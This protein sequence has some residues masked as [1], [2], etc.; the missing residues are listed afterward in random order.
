MITPVNVPK[1]GMAEGDITV[2]EWLRGDGEQVEAGAAIL[3]I[4]TAKASSEVEAPANGILFCLRQP[5]DMVKT[6]DLLGAIADSA[7][8]FET[9]KASLE[10]EGEAGGESEPAKQANTADTSGTNVAKTETAD[11]PSLTA[12]PDDGEARR[13]PLTGMRLAIARNMVASLQDA[14]QMTVVAETDL[15]ELGEFRK[16]LMLDS[17]EEKITYVDIFCKLAA[18]VLKEFPAVNSSIVGNEIVYWNHCNVGFAVALDGG[19]VVPVIKDADRKSLSAVSREISKLSR[20]ARENRLGA[21][22]VEG[23]TFTVTSGGRNEVEF[24]TPIINGHQSAILGLGKVGPKPAIHQ[25]ELAIRTIVHLCLTHDHRVV[26][27]VVAGEFVGRLKDLAQNREQFEK[28]L[29]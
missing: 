6:G 13:E 22:D 18:F 15:T 21:E 5:E 10:D 26:D 11:E 9:F 12:S 8:E 23:G 2:V 20:K 17:P 28:I 16:K 19:L 27:G 4:E 29:R 3:V 7:E 24:M 25:G 1:M 14:A